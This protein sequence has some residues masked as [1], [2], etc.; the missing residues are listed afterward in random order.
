[1]KPMAASMPWTTAVGQNSL[2]A[3]AR[4]MPKATCTIPATQPTAIAIR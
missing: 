4:S 3:P 2:S 1:M